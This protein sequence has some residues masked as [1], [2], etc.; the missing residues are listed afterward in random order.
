MKLDIRMFYD[1][2]PP[3]NREAALDMMLAFEHM[4]R[5][6]ARPSGWI[7][8]DSE[9]PRRYWRIGGNYVIVE[10]SWGLEDMRWHNFLRETR[11]LKYPAI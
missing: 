2:S 6:P 11:H 10:R 4:G 3:C 7:G 9:Y 8:E 5:I 1:G